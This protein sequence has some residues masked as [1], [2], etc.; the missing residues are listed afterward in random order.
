MKPDINNK[1]H[2]YSF[3]GNIKKKYS[4]YEDRLNNANKLLNDTYEYLNEKKVEIFKSFNLDLDCYITEW[5]NKIYNDKLSLYN[6][7]QSI[8]K[9]CF[10]PV[11]RLLILQICKY[12]ALLDN[13]R[14]YNNDLKFAIEL[15]NLKYREWERY[16]CKYYF[17]VHKCILQGYAYAYSNG[18]GDILINR[19]KID[20]SNKKCIDFEETN[21]R[22]KALLDAGKK[23]YNKNEAEW[24]KERGLT[25]DG[26]D[27]RVY[28][29]DNY[30]YEIVIINTKVI[31]H[32]KKEFERTE[33]V[34]KELK[35]LGYKKVADSCKTIEDIYMIPSDIRF[36]LN[37][38]LYKYPNEYLKFIRNEDQDKYKLGTHNS[39]NRQRFQPR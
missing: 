26:I 27:Y 10:N 29:K 16:V 38:L 19:W 39:K 13:C 15:K 5:K 2:Y 21:K 3:L 31:P 12:C 36:K 24:Y 7:A 34:K 9:T 30:Y 25:Y 35:G 20:N 11:K 33:Y 6:K 4:I 8:L 22:K 37:A 14:K 1:D 18:I 17:N 23:L 28:K 32:T